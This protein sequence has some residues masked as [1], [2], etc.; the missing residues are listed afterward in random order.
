MERLQLRREAG[1]H[2]C[3]TVSKC[4]YVKRQDPKKGVYAEMSPLLWSLVQSGWFSY[5]LENKGKKG[6]LHPSHVFTK[7]PS[8][9]TARVME[10][11][12]EDTNPAACSSGSPKILRWSSNIHCLALHAGMVFS[13]RYGHPNTPAIYFQKML[14]CHL[15]ATMTYRYPF[16]KVK[17]V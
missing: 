6:D 13:A 14:I 17:L 4:N 11:G 10:R 7:R 15:S 16:N 9:D 8:E 12:S 2:Y 1:K 3:I 5:K